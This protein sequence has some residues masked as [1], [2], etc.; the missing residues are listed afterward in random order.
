MIKFHLFARF[1]IKNLRKNCHYVHIPSLGSSS[2]YTLMGKELGI[3]EER[4]IAL[5]SPAKNVMLAIVLSGV[6]IARLPGET[7]CTMGKQCLWSFQFGVPHGLCWGPRKVILLI[8]LSGVKNKLC[9]Q[10]RPPTHERTIFMVIKMWTYKSDFSHCSVWGI[11][12]G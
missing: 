9:Y 6:L 1:P 10:E 3:G 2:L 11:F 8:V 7:T 5:T 12:N 4:P